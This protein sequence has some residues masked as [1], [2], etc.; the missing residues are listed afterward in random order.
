MRIPK[1]TALIAPVLAAAIVAVAALLAVSSPV[2][3]TSA[4]GKVV[5]GHATIEI[6][7]FAYHPTT[8]TVT[9]GTKVTILNEDDVEHTVT[10]NAEGLF[11]TGAL[12]HGQ[13]S[14]FTLNKPGTYE[15]HCAFHAFMHGTIKVVER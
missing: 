15:Y 6:K 13:S 11:E 1:P 5:S 3:S 2:S 12:H 8:I 10:S 14:S 7:D 4:A 9:A